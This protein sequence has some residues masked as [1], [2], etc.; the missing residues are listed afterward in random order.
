MVF[1]NIFVVIIF[2]RLNEND[3]F[4]YVY[5]NKWGVYYVIY[6]MYGCEVVESRLI[7]DFCFIF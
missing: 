5:Y 6:G 3:S 1:I 7:D 2:Y 4:Y